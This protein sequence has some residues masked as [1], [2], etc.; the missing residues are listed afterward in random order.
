[1]PSIFTFSV[2]DAPVVEPLSDDMI[3]ITLDTE[4]VVDATARQIGAYNI[5]VVAGSGEAVSVR[6]VLLPQDSLTA[7]EII[8]VVDKPTHGTHYRV[9]ATGLNGRD[10][11]LVGG[12]SDFIGR[13]T[14]TEEI[15]RAMPSHYNIS[16]DS[17]LRSVL[18]AI[19]IQDETI[20]GSRNDTFS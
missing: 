2:E 9:T 17:I 18:T 13:R 5:S 4:I 19:G 8:L 11:T 6:K 15:L 10:G 1:M 20:G 16:A 14:K 7:S 3:K 12:A